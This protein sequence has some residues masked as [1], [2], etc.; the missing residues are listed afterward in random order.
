MRKINKSQYKSVT[1]RVLITSC[2]ISAVTLLASSAFASKFD[3]DAG[4]TAAA[5]PL[6]NGLKA[7]WGK[8]VMLTGGASA[9]LGEGDARQRALRAGI[10]CAAGGAVILGLIATLT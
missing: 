1:K 5:D 10:G 4:V 6:I 8:G 2:A 9:L 3:L 7:H